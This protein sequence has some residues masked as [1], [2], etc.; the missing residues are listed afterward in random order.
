M[1]TKRIA[2]L[3]HQEFNDVV[4]REWNQKSPKFPIVEKDSIFSTLLTNKYPKAASENWVW[5][6]YKEKK[7]KNLLLRLYIYI[8][9]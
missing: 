5:K 9:I 3:L 8:Y 7:K 2:C 4:P 1:K 6:L